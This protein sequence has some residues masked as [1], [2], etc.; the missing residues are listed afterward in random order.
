MRC[1]Y[2]RSKRDKVVD[3]R[4]VRGNQAVRRRRRE[5]D[6][7]TIELGNRVGKTNQCI[8]QYEL[9]RRRISLSV[10]KDLAAALGTR[11]SHIVREAERTVSA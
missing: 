10:L 2:C 1:P 11:P 7:T 3:S 8:G 5:K 4:S 9:G 6:M